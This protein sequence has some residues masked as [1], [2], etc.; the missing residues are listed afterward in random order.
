MQRTLYPMLTTTAIHSSSVMT[1]IPC[2]FRVQDQRRRETFWMVDRSID[3]RE[4]KQKFI[5]S[6]API[7]TLT[8]AMKAPLLSNAVG[9]TVDPHVPPSAL[10]LFEQSA[11]LGSTTDEASKLDFQQVLRDLKDLDRFYSE[12]A[13]K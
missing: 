5:W 10:P 1:R 7:P 9:L 11:S 6:P 13:D 4:K 3:P 2:F 12:R 8:Q